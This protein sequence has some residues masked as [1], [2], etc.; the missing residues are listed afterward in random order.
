MGR[1]SAYTR[2]L[3]G[4]AAA[5]NIAVGA[6]FLFFRPTLAVLAGVGPTP[7]INVTLSYLLGS[8]ILLFGYA[9]IL[10]ARDPARYRLY[11]HLAVIGK[12]MAWGS[13]TLS[14]IQGNA[15]P[16]LPVLMSV[17]LVYAVLFL[18]YLRSVPEPVA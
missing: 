13:V 2:W 9:Y 16:G 6:L 4:T 11:I 7:I 12:L 1:S 18:L 8:F 15:E 17:D 5:L 3:F 10:I 14:W